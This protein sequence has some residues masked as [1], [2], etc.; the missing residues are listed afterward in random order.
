VQQQGELP[1]PI[2]SPEEEKTWKDQVDLWFETSPQQAIRD[3]TPEIKKMEL[4]A[5][6]SVEREDWQQLTR[7]LLATVSV[8]TFLQKFK[9][10]FSWLHYQA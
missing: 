10:M 1:Y 9:T 4:K 7:N 3:L 2:L 5:V 6:L 8:V